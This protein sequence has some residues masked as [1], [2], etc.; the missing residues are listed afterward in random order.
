MRRESDEN[1]L[2]ILLFFENSSKKKFWI[3]EGEEYIIDTLSFII[4]PRLFTTFVH[5]P[6]IIQII[7]LF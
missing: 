2:L 3:K 5:F 7:L 6:V 1:F 4:E